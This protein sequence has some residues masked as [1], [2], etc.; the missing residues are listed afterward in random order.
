VKVNV[1][2]RAVINN[3]YKTLTDATR[4]GFLI[5][6]ERNV[7][8]KNMTVLHWPLPCRLNTLCWP[9]Y[10]RPHYVRAPVTCAP[11]THNRKVAEARIWWQQ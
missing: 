10:R 3:L 8:K 5:Q 4:S 11:V 7:Q 6:L 2:A 1:H 9:P